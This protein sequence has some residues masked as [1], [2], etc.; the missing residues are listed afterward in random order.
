VYV[1]VSGPPGSGKSTVGR[2]LADRLGLLLLSKDTIKEIL[3]DVLGA[4]DLR[5]SQRLGLASHQALLAVAAENGSGVL[6]STWR[7]S[8]ATDELRRLPGVIVEVF[9]ACDPALAR[10][11][12][13]HRAADRHPGHFDAAHVEADDLWSGEVAAPVDGGWPLR[14]LDTST[15]FDA[16]EL[17][18]WVLRAGDGR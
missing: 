1:V 13:A 3:F 2:A 6:E 7:A 8:L 11:R 16:D 18:Q 15:T 17:C 4:A 12:Y 10:T 9:C 14:R 5:E